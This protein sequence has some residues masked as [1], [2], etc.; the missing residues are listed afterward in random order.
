MSTSLHFATYRIPQDVDLLFR[1]EEVV[2]LEPLAVRALRY[3]AENC[4]RV[5]PIEEL[6][7]RVWPD[8]FTTDLV[9]KRA[10]SLARRA[11]DDDPKSPRFIR[12]YHGRGY[13]FVAPVTRAGAEKTAAPSGTPADDA[14]ERPRA[15]LP[16]RLTSFVARERDLA[17]A[18]HMLAETRLLTLTGPGGVG[19]TRLALEVADAHLDDFPD[20]VWLVDLATVRDPALVAETIARA[21]GAPVVSEVPSLSGSLRDAS[22]WWT[23]APESRRRSSPSVRACGSSRPLARCSAF[24]AKPSG[25]FPGSSRLPRGPR[26][27]PPT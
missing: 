15:N 9:L 11:L 1:D 25:R 18:W 12:T 17:V 14:A 5:V 26:T 20:G 19:K 13:R 24:S 21:V 8:V 23:R 27:P 6:L 7:E 16:K 3:L 22:S 4:D 10:V 2:P